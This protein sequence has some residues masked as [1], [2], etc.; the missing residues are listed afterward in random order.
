MYSNHDD[1]VINDSSSFDTNEPREYY[2]E[3]QRILNQIGASHGITSDERGSVKL[4]KSRGRKGR[5]G[6]TASPVPVSAK[7]EDGER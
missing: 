3:I 4:D 6:A 5:T 1:N 7:L 2:S